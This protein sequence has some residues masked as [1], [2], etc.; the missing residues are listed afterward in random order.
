MDA[1]RKC[2]LMVVAV[3]V[4]AAPF[5]TALAQPVAAMPAMMPV[6]SVLTRVPA[7]CV[8]FVAVRS[9]ANMG[10]KIDQFIADI[11]MQAMMPGNLL[12]MIKAQLMMTNGI[13]D[14]GG[15]AVIML[16]PEKFGCDLQALMGM[17]PTTQ[18]ATPSGPL[19]IAF[20]IPGRP[21]EIFAN[22]NP[23]EEQGC[24][25][26]D[27]PGGG[28]PAFAK[29]LGSYTVV[30]PVLAVVDAVVSSTRPVIVPP[31]HADL[32]AKCEVACHV[33][34]QKLAPI[35]AVLF[36][37]I[38]RQMKQQAQSEFTPP[39]VKAMMSVYGAL[40]PMYK[41]SI[42]QLQAITIGL[43]L[44]KTGIVI[45]EVASYLPDSTFGQ[46]AAAKKF[47][48]GPLLSKLPDLPYVLALG[49]AEEAPLDAAAMALKKKT[50]T[51]ILDAVLNSEALAKVSVETKDRLKKIM[52]TWSDECTGAQVCIGGSTP[53]NGLFGVSLVL[54]AK[55]AKTLTDTCGELAQI[56]DELIKALF[57]ENGSDA[58]SITYTA[59]VGQVA[60][61]D[62]GV[63]ELSHPELDALDE[64]DRAEMAKVLGEDKI[65]F[66]VAAVDPRTV[67][68]TF[69]GSQAFLAEAINATRTGKPIDNYPSVMEAMKELPANPILLMVFSPAN[70]LAV[71]K[72]GV[73]TIAGPE[74]LQS[75]PWPMLN[76]QTQTP[77]AIGVALKG[78][79]VHETVFV[80]TALVAEGVRT[81]MMVMQPP[82]PPAEEEDEEDDES[83]EDDEAD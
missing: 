8:G 70:L 4:L 29:A 55:N 75:H 68:I 26:V 10:A 37:Q 16:D 63:F 59:S 60:G 34:M 77:I 19:P 30:S 58:P 2:Q 35:V 41:D 36:D 80:P 65:R 78:S 83:W 61:A 5:A 76:I 33:D 52:E 53:G 11:G 31:G 22:Y 7:E 43:R 18:P 21:G 17:S 51:E 14:N 49:V 25:K 74:I 46:L 81:V 1:I 50:E 54:R 27:L 38:E 69:G 72:G 3:A 24:F 12:G 47:I 39:P 28:S 45:E 44:A 15:L 32:F 42:T 57:A 82:M 40:L 79:A 13:N 73:A 64:G 20:L 6:E 67:V 66:Y 71:V 56:K 48:P 23:V 9:L 62:V